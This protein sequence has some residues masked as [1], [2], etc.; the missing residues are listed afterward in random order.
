M[1]STK[2]TESRPEGSRKKDGIMIRRPA[3]AS[4]AERDAYRVELPRTQ[5]SLCF[6]VSPTQRSR[7]LLYL[8]GSSFSM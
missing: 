6:S 7:N 8:T 2:A 3:A 1:N 4:T 5:L